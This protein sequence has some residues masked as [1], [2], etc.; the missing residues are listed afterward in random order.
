VF[1]LTKKVFLEA[2][3]NGWNLHSLYNE[4]FEYPPEGYKF[5][6]GK[7]S[8]SD[9]QDLIHSFNRRIVRQNATKTLYDYMRPSFYYLLT[10]FSNSAGLKSVDLTFSSQHVIFRKEPWIVDVEHAGALAAYGKIV[11]IKKLVE[12][13]LRSDYCK[14]IIPWT[15]K[16]KETILSN[17]NCKGFENKI[18]IVNLAVRPKLFRKRFDNDKIKLL[19]VG[20]ANQVNIG[21]CFSIKGGREV[22]K[23]FEILSSKYADLELVMRSHFPMDIK[24]RYVNFKNLRIIDTVV[25]WKVLEREFKTADIFLFPGHSTPGMAILD[26]MSYELPV[27]ATDVWA[28]NELVEDGK[29]GCLIRGSSKVRYHDETFVPL[30]GEPSFMNAIRQVDDRMVMELAKKTS[31]LIEDEKLRRKMG[32]NGRK[33]IEMGKFSIKTR[34]QRLKRIFDE[35]IESKCEVLL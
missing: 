30:W 34:N 6:V 20:T 28:N 14:K 21:D 4:L 3:M 24:R 19:F 27:V 8:D 35:A 18:E 2:R 5:V 9:S 12:K 22:L 15:T 26:A 10:K 32:R 23:A 25:P 17:F 11:M 29:T 7:N 33:E 16:G 13:A 31:E 1:E